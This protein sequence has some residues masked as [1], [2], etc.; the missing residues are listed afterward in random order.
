VHHVQPLGG[1]HRGKDTNDNML[2]VCPNHHAMFDYGI[3]EFV[4]L[5][6]VRIGTENFKLT[7]KHSFSDQVMAYHNECL[8]HS[9]INPSKN[10]SDV[11]KDF[12]NHVN[13]GSE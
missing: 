2:V 6:L 8:R 7:M 1:V 12:L 13:V 5:N 9:A 10:S 3:P 11:F 4:A